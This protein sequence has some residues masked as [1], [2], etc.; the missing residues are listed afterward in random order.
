MNVDSVAEHRNQDTTE[1]KD[2]G[3]YDSDRSILF[4]SGHLGNKA[5]RSHGK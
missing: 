1:G 2:A 5:N 4:D 3:V